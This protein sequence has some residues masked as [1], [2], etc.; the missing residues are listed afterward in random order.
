MISLLRRLAKISSAYSE[1]VMGSSPSDE[2]MSTK[3]GGEGRAAWEEVCVG[4]QLLNVC[5]AEKSWGKRQ[6][7]SALTGLRRD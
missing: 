5:F 2:S 3:A 4:P 7:M 1:Q 6:G